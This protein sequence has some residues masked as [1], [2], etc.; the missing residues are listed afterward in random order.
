[1]NPWEADPIVPDGPPNAAAASPAAPPSPG[2]PIRMAGPAPAPAA[3]TT[4]TLPPPSYVGG[5]DAPPLAPDD[6]SGVSIQSVGTAP[7]ANDPEATPAAPAAKP[8]PTFPLPQKPMTP[9]LARAEADAR[10]QLKDTPGAE[11]AFANGF[12]LNGATLAAPVIN[13]ATTGIHNWF[14]HLVG[15]PDAGYSAQ[16][17]YDATKAVYT[18][19]LAQY[20]QDHPVE[21]TVAGLAGAVTNPIMRAGGGW[22]AGGK[23]LPGIVARGVAFNA[24]IGAAYG[25]FGAPDGQRVQGAV[26][27]GLLGAG[28][29]AAAPV[30][31]A[32]ASPVIRALQD[33]L[34]AG[35]K[36]LPAA[37]EA[38]SAL[39]PG[40]SG[41]GADAR[42]SALDAIKR[43]AHPADATMMAT[44]KTLPVPVP[45][46]VGQIT[47][48]P[49]QQLAENMALRG[50]R[51]QDAGIY[52]RDFQMQQQ[53]ALRGNVDA[54]R[55][56]M[57]GET[58]PPPGAGGAMVS[59]ALNARYAAAKAGVDAAY[60]TARAG[61][62]A[63]MPAYDAQALYG[64][65]RSAVADFDPLNI[66]RVARELGNLQDLTTAGDPEATQLFQARTRLSQLRAS[67][68]PVERAAAARAVKAFDTTIS[69]H[70][71]D[72]LFHGDPQTVANWRAAI[73]QRRGFGQLFQGNDLIQRLTSREP[74]GG[75]MQLSVD[76]HDAT[77]YILGRSGLG[78]VGRQGLYRDLGR[79]RDTL[80]TDSPGWNA[81]RADA[82]S[83]I[84][85]AGEGGVEAG[86]PQ[87]SGVKFLKSW[88]AANKADPQLM[89]TLFSDEERATINRFG[90]IASR[91]TSPV[92]G[93][94]NPSNTAV[95]AGLAAIRKLPFV[96][97][98]SL[99]FVDHIA[100]TLQN[101]ANVNAIKS[102]TI[103]AAPR[104]VR[105][106][107]AGVGGMI[108]TS[109]QLPQMNQG[110][111]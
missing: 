88:Q 57:A 45:M 87:F 99:P 18:P 19:A 90:S 64:N 71:S 65:V 105:P 33:L 10:L 36:A 4:P 66:P 2:P 84:A 20:A 67:N 68:D 92:R 73:A 38:A 106:M 25:G 70:L 6:G 108:G 31:G 27:G 52:A 61:A 42:Q 59:D 29:G 22:V 82:F 12:F 56:G 95:A 17:A 28:I 49:G 81:L 98:K 47:G 102:A 74:I 97:L 63:R 104:S 53:A 85:A 109:L 91:V 43:G 58:A 101:A 89:S 54:I 76:P 1:M 40:W 14:S 15:L 30:A 103:R 24:P 94:D 37:Q 51:G 55:T 39:G 11:A 77:N 8:T 32:M 69:D 46:S 107:P 41:I 50:A 48:E 100:D 79:L 3:A 7:W 78:F 96:V 110:S 111:Q 23:S 13:Q 21:N 5:P 75:Q 35:S 86:T 72:D 26:E 80:G 83:R 60:D 16:D 93:G 9:Q 44:A 34:P 62:P